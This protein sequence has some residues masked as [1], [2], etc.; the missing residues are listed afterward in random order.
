[1]FP[2]VIS[3]DWRQLLV[4][5][6]V[7]GGG[8]QLAAAGLI[9][10][11]AWLA[12]I[13]IERAWEHP[14]SGTARRSSP[15]PGRIPG[16]WPGCGRRPRA[17]SDWY[18]QATR[19]M[20]WRSG[21]GMRMRR[22]NWALR[23]WLLSAGTGIPISP[24]CGDLPAGAKLQLQLPDGSWR[25]Y[26]GGNQW[27]WWMPAHSHCLPRSGRS[28]CCWSPVTPSTRCRQT[29]RCAT[30]L[31]PGL[32]WSGPAGSTACETGTGPAFACYNF[33]P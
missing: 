4:L 27:K 20:P 32:R 10:A 7:L 15:G 22:R 23:G 1:M 18:W 9:K 26:R 24:S 33:R 19:A 12:P 16:R 31:G 11:K 5:L 17:W 8:Q 14:S 30:W 3:K 25:D 6:L 21:P 2:T 29:A 13:L 28:C